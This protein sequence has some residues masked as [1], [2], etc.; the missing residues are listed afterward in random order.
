MYEGQSPGCVLNGE[1][2]LGA[3]DALLF[4]SVKPDG[5][6]DP[7]ALHTGCPVVTGVKWTATIWIHTLPFHPE[8][9]AEHRKGTP[10]PASDR[11][12]GDCVDY[13]DA[14]PNWAKG[15]GCVLS[16]FIKSPR[17]FLL[18]RDTSCSLV[19]CLKK[20]FVLGLG[21]T[22]GIC[23]D[24]KGFFSLAATGIDTFQ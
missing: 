11:D 24:W 10:D 17:C 20:S 12:P 3:G 4:Y 7:K 9:L 18:I 6:Q 1:V 13:H 16:G 23:L 2:S 21:R 15:N 22:H 19:G 8:W 14:C 5:T